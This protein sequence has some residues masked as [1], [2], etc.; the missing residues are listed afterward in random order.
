MW[1]E[2]FFSAPQLKR[3]P[4]GARPLSDAMFRPGGRFAE[5]EWTQEGE[6]ISSP[7]KLAAIKRTL[8]ADGPVLLEHKFLR[9]GRAPHTLVFDDYDDLIAYLTNHARAGDKISVWRLWPFMRETPPLAHGKCPDHDGAVPK[10]GA[11]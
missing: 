4:L 5:D 1:N 3:D 11:Y 7:E 10:H 8:E 2:A 6:K 9:G